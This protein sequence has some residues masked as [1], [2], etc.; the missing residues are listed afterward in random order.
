MRKLTLFI[1]LFLF[2]NVL[3]ATLLMTGTKQDG[4][5]I[6]DNAILTFDDECSF[7]CPDQAD[8]YKWEFKIYYYNETT[9]DTITRTYYESNEKN[10]YFKIDEFPA[11]PDHSWVFGEKESEFCSPPIKAGITLTIKQ[12]DGMPMMQTMTVFLNLHPVSTMEINVVDRAPLGE[13][14]YYDWCI[15]KFADVQY[16]TGKI[17][18]F[19][20]ED[21][22][23]E[24]PIEEYIWPV[25]CCVNKTEN[26]DIIQY[27]A[28]NRYGWIKGVEYDLFKI[29]SEYD[30]TT[31]SSQTVKTKEFIRSTYVNNLLYLKS[32]VLHTNDI[33]RIFSTS[34]K[35]IIHLPFNGQDYID[36]HS[37]LEGI[38][39]IQILRD[40][41]CIYQDKIIL[42]H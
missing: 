42:K 5:P 13:D 15:L 18:F 16:A 26:N 2:C 17:V 40:N 7:K 38:Y 29:L 33:I 32:D 11:L 4:S 35:E 37:H 25:K 8:T 9:E 41:C 30:P 39:F 6:L 12:E 34:G 23:T 14:G 22:Y 1:G 31:I 24:Y 36:L 21:G 20:N 28:F 10:F 19:S 3:K 27:R